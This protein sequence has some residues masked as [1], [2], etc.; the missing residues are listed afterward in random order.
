MCDDGDHEV[1]EASIHERCQDAGKCRIDI[2]DNSTEQ[3]T[4]PCKLQQFL[5]RI[6]H[7]WALFFVGF[8]FFFLFKPGN[9]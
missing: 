2:G 7:R 8:F 4:L 3:Y 6:R 5:L 1:R 9:Q